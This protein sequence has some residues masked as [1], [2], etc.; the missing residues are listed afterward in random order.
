M[1]K[2]K[3]SLKNIKSNKRSQKK[4]QLKKWNRLV[5]YSIVD[6]YWERSFID[7]RIKLWSLWILK[8]KFK[9]RK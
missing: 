9:L 8:L 2:G 1:G 6:Q 7:Q 4:E 5:K 3:T